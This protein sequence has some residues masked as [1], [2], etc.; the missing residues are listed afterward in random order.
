MLGISLLAALA[1]VASAAVTVRT[2]NF[3]GYLTAPDGT[4]INTT[5]DMTF[6]IYNAPTGGTLIWQEQHFEPPGG[7][8]GVD[9][10]QGVF[11]VQ[12]GNITP[13][14]SNLGDDLY[15]EVQINVDPPLSPRFTYTGAPFAF[16]AGDVYGRDI[17]PNTPAPPAG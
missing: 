7:V 10:V 3:Q 12:L 13:L 1:D 14:P 17:N 2:L 4:P 15:V 16:Q 8:A 9:I 11:S 5:V 6:R